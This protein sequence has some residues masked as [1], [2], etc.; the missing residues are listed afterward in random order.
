[1]NGS[2]WTSSPPPLAP[3]RGSSL[4]SSASEEPGRLRAGER[5]QG[6]AEV[7]GPLDDPGAV[8]RPGRTGTPAVVTL[9]RPHREGAHPDPARE[10]QQPLRVGGIGDL[11]PPG[12]VVEPVHDRRAL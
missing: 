10:I 11:G 5:L 8:V 4:A 2:P 7:P 1:M 12:V 6:V 9:D 3:M